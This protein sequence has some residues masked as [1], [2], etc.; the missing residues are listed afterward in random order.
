[1]RLGKPVQIILPT[2][3]DEKKRLPQKRRTDRVKRLQ[4]EAT[5]AWNLYSALYYKAGG[6]PWR[7]VRDSFQLTV[8]YVGVSFYKTL[9]GSRL[10]TSTAQVFNER[11]DGIILR[12]GA[13][14][15]SKEDRQ[16]HLQQTG[17]YKLL[18]DALKAY[19]GEHHNLPARVVVQKTSTYNKEE[20]EGF[21]EAIQGHHVDS[22]DFLSVRDLSTRL[23]RYG[24]YPP[25]RGILLSKDETTHMLYTR[26]SVD[27]F[28]TYPGLYLPRPLELRCEE[29]EQTPGFL[30]REILALTKM[31][32]NNTQ[33]DNDEPI[34]V[35]AARRVGDILKYIDEGEFFQERYSF[36]M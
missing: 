36:Y 27:F 1:M 9:D 35:R 5:R 17:A 13:A 26:G 21:R 7:L 19:K 28:S 34:T 6:T 22:A 14:T 29:T 11:G 15:I 8:C 4:D 30:A 2:T 20:L 24:K 32:W 33:F 23:F 10:M 3:Y 18:D 25:L 12:G 31:N 16:P